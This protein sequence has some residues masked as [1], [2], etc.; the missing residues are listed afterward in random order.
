MNQANID[1]L[2]TDIDSII[3][4]QAYLDLIQNA[5]LPVCKGSTVLEIAPYRGWHT[6]LILKQDPKSITAVEPDIR[7]NKFLELPNVELVNQDIFHYLETP[8]EFD[9]VVCFG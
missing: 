1:D 3:T 5:Y 4:N 7:H 8:H 6:R 9:V 2:F